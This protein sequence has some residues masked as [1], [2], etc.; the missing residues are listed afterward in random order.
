MRKTDPEA[1]H[2]LA[3]LIRAWL[4]RPREVSPW[5]P[6]KRA[7]LPGLHRVE[8][9]EAR[10]LWTNQLDCLYQLAARG[11]WVEGFSKKNLL[12]LILTSGP[13]ER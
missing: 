13:T 2:P 3:P 4:D 5:W 1:R 10:E 9:I 8:V 11:F 6:S 7:S 12:L